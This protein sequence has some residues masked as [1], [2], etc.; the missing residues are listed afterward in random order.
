MAVVGVLA[1]QGSFNEH[2]AGIDGH[3]PIF[4][5]LIHVNHFFACKRVMGVCVC[6]WS[7]SVEEGGCEGCG[8]KEG[9]AAA[10]REGTHY[11][12]RREHHHGQACGIS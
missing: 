3:Y 9:G 11:P 2:M 7:C 1:L 12:W 6:E 10:K 5:S 4:T 8:D